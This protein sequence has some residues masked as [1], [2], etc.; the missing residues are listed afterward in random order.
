LLNKRA[1]EIK[2]LVSD[3]EDQLSEQLHLRLDPDVQATLLVIL[4]KDDR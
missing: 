1:N 2:K 4:E 3:I